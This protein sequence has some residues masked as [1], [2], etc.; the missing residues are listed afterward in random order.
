MSEETRTPPNYGAGGQRTPY[1]LCR[2]H[3]AVRDLCCAECVNVERINTGEKM[4]HN[5][6]KCPVCRID[7]TADFVDSAERRVDEKKFGE[8]V[9]LSIQDFR[10]LI[11][12]AHAAPACT[13]SEHA[14]VAWL[15]EYEVNGRW[16][17]HDLRPA[18]P[19]PSEGHG[20][21]SVPLYRAPAYTSTGQEPMNGIQ[22]IAAER[23]RQIAKG[24]DS[25]HD[26]Q[27]DDAMIVQVA[28]EIIAYVDPTVSLDVADPWGII[29]RTER[30]YP[31]ENDS[32]LR[33]LVIAGALI[34]AEIDRRQ[35]VAPAF[36]SGGQEGDKGL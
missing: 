24:Y 17:H 12:L 35:R 19:A 3:G 13:A 28:Q 34:A 8:G 29:K 6:M 1:A 18:K 27:H 11:E 33:L 23:E 36:E 2:A 30:K 26:D 32:D 10:R 20:W 31:N 9:L 22:L 21:R 5:P 16:H 4:E 7:A 14:P 15:M 25:T